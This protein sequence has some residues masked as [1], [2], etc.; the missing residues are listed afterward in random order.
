MRKASFADMHCSIAQ[1]LEIVGEWWTLLILRDAFLG[2]R[3]FDDFVERLGISRNV[4]TNRLDTLV[5]AGILERRPYDEARG[6]YDYLL[7]DKG[8]ALWPVMTALR[9]WGDEWIYGTGN[10]PLLAR[11]P[12][13][14]MHHH[15]R[16]DLQ[17]V[18]RTPRRPIGACRPGA[19]RDERLG[20]GRPLN[21]ASPHRAVRTK[22]G[23]DP[24]KVLRKIVPAE[25]A[26]SC[27][28]RTAATRGGATTVEA[29]ER[30]VVPSPRGLSAGG[31][32]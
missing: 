10:E 6:R 9:Q 15:R 18:R 26:R 14:R 22:P 7:T 11:A 20:A 2:V 31:A 28:E 25:R 16:D 13:L 24:P 27:A 1:S 12:K 23:S 30:P 4:L 21:H 19:R 5:A 8:R 29:L 17:R 32:R 3:R